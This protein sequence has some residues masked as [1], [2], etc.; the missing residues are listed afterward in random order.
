[1]PKRINM[2]KDGYGVDSAKLLRIRTRLGISQ[3]QAAKVSGAADRQSWHRWETGSGSPS[4]AQMHQFTE[5]V[6]L[7]FEDVLY[8]RPE[9]ENSRCFYVSYAWLDDG[10]H[11]YGSRQIKED[12][13]IT[14][15]IVESW[16]LSI[17]G[18]HEAQSVT[19]LFWKELGSK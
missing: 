16:A 15:S 2:S 9:R 4:C 17:K 14:M 8:S 6:G 3:G 13:E 10:G 12:K 19:V 1:M 5:T 18:S 11:N 7:K